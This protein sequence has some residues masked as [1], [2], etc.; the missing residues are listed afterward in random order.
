M[1]LCRAGDSTWEAILRF[2]R[3]LLLLGS[4]TLLLLLSQTAFADVATEQANRLNEI[5][6]AV[7]SA[8]TATNNIKVYQQQYD[9]YLNQLPDP[10]P[11]APGQQQANTQPTPPQF[12][13]PA[14]TEQ[15]QQQ[16]EVPQTEQQPI[17]SGF[18]DDAG[19]NNSGSGTSNWDYGF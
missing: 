14:T 10:T 3:E 11:V 18:G 7:Q 15:A 5:N 17:I 4:S 1:R 16:Q 8:N 9:N 12:Q 6:Q 2:Q 19:N 13:L